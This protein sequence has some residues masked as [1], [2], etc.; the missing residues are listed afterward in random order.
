MKVGFWIQSHSTLKNRTNKQ[1]KPTKNNFY[2]YLA[3]DKLIYTK[4]FVNLVL[5]VL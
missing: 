2:I 4:Q 3:P 5:K 1:K